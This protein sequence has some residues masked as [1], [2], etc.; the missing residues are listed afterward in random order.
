MEHVEAPPHTINH[1]FIHGLSIMFDA[2]KV[3]WFIIYLCMNLHENHQTM[4]G[5]VLPAQ[6]LRIR[7][8]T[9]EEFRQWTGTGH[10]GTQLQPSL[11]NLPCPYSVQ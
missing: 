11:R 4:S 1:Y 3:T 8:V 9:P 2:T 10:T 5:S 7:N 6:E